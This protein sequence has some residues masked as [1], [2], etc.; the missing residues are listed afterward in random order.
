[1]PLVSEVTLGVALVVHALIKWQ[2]RTLVGG[3]LATL[4]KSNKGAELPTKLS[5][6]SGTISMHQRQWPHH[7]NTLLGG[8]FIKRKNALPNNVRCVVGF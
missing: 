7:K 8:V 4:P 6:L 3:P 2:P 1:V 5:S